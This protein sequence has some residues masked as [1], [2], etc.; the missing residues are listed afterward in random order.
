M[1][2]NKA[3][4]QQSIHNHA[5]ALRAPLST[6]ILPS[7]ALKSAW[8]HSWWKGWSTQGERVCSSLNSDVLFDFSCSSNMAKFN[9]APLLYYTFILLHSSVGHTCLPPAPSPCSLSPY[10]SPIW[11]HC[12]VL[13]QSHSFNLLDRSPTKHFRV[14]HCKDGL[15]PP[16]C[17]AIKSGVSMGWNNYGLLQL[18]ASENC[19]LELPARRVISEPAVC[20]SKLSLCQKEPVPSALALAG[21]QLSS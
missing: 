5:A 11:F 6:P 10:L 14:K 19:P 8:K 15:S 7:P 12:Y 2:S 21:P 4:H 3:V 13:M 17:M 1:A 9:G 16:Q 20:N 18:M